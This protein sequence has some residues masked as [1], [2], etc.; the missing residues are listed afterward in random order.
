M[1]LPETL[2]ALLGDALS[3]NGDANDRLLVADADERAVTLHSLSG[4]FYG[5]YDGSPV[6]SAVEQLA[7][8]HQTPYDLPCLK[9]AFDEVG[10]VAYRGGRAA[11]VDMTKWYG[12]PHMRA[13]YY[14]GLTIGWRAARRLRGEQ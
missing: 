4:V 10:R 3:V 9:H 11:V 7:A 2:H 8:L 12:R 13:A 1:T 14:L 6:E 5:R